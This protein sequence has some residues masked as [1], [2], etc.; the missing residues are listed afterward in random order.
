MANT[1]KK[2]KK[3][4]LLFK[5]HFPSLRYLKSTYKW[6]IQSSFIICDKKLKSKLSHLP[7]DLSIYYVEAGEKLKDLFYFDH[8]VRIIMQK[9]SKSKQ[10]PSN[11]ISIGGGSVSDFVGF[12]SSVYK[13]GKPVYHIPTTLLS[14][15][16]ASHGGKTALNASSVKNVIGSY[17]FPQSVLIVRDLLLPCAK[18]ELQ[19]FYGELLKIAFINNKKL[20]QTLKSD[21]SPSMDRIWKLLPLGVGSKMDIVERDPL[22]K[23]DIRLYL[24]FGH[25][26]GHCIEAYHKIPHGQAVAYGMRFAISWSI[27]KKILKKE[28]GKRMIDMIE[29]Y[30]DISKS[31]RIPLSQLERL[32]KEDKKQTSLRKIKFVFLKDITKPHVQS[33]NIK[34]FLKFYQKTR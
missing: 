17:H 26:L 4:N 14:A 9:I 16:D 10:N 21:L 12:F 3:T 22:E 28:Q 19:S 29:S 24:N 2:S 1:S 33:V 7:T 30:V 15:L 6:P 27:D 13:R 25:T 11:F 8:H 31:Y 5:T 32:V 18:K 34:D 20:Y 23:K